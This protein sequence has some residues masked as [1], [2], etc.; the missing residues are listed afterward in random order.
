MG[1]DGGVCWVKV[2]GD[3]DRFMGLVEPLG[4]STWGTWQEDKHIKWLEDHS[5]EHAGCTVATYG[6]FQEIQ[7]YEDLRQVLS[8]VLHWDTKDSCGD[9]FTELTFEECLLAI[10]TRPHYWWGYKSRL[11]EVLLLSIG[12]WYEMAEV[13]EYICKRYTPLLTMNVLDWAK[14]VMGLV[15]MYSWGSAETWT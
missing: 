7:G 14:E 12:F 2:T 11:E 6:D 1:A 15:D 8:E 9:N 3:V 4:F 10:Q 13:P 5:E